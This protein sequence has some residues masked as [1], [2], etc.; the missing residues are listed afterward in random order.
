MTYKKSWS[1]IRIT[2]G[3]K[4]KVSHHLYSEEAA[5]LYEYCAEARTPRDIA[6]HFGNEPSVQAALQEFVAKDLMLFLDGRYLSLALPENPNFDLVDL[7]DPPA[8]HIQKQPEAQPTAVVQ[9]A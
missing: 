6:S 2:D 8:R 3:R 9:I 7:P 4:E 5:A 1:S